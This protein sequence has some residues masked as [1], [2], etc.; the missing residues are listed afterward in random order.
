MHIHQ[1]PNCSPNDSGVDGAIVNAGAA[2]GH[3]NPTDA[4]HGFPA[5]AVHHVG[6]MGNIMI[7]DGGT[8]K[9]T[10][11][12]KDWTVQPGAKSVVGHALV[13]HVQAD[14]GTSQPVGDAGS[15]PGCGVIVTP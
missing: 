3:W 11:V 4:G 14:D 15:R 13:F 5:A 6:D 7:V 8:G 12:S 1:N 9:L 2:G 10:L